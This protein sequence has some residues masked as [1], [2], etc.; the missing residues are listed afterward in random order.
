MKTLLLLAACGLFA[1]TGKAS[2]T[3]ALDP[4]GVAIVA[5]SAGRIVVPSPEYSVGGQTLKPVWTP[6]A[7]GASGVVKYDNGFELAV[8]VDSSAGTI[9]YDYT[10]ATIVA[11]AMLRFTTILPTTFNDAG[12]YSL[13]RAP[14]VEFPPA[15]IDQ[16]LVRGESTHVTFVAPTGDGFSVE[17]PVC[18]QAVQ[19]NRKWNWNVFAW[20]YLYDLNKVPSRRAFTFK[21]TPGTP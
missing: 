21:V 3:L 18:W 1:L 13:D 20:V 10:A 4:K 17:A 15:F 2:I 19:D 9:T 5:G 8:K 12:R 14:L 11:G 6:S 7:E 16:H